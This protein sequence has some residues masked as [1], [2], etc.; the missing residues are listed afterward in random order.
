M[1]KNVFPLFGELLCKKMRMKK[2]TKMNDRSPIYKHICTSSKQVMDLH[3]LKEM[4]EENMGRPT[5]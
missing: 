2:L 1:H 3:N 5:T 4:N